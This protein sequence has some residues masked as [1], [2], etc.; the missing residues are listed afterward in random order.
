[1]A[2][3]DIL[4]EL[5]SSS[6]LHFFCIRTGAEKTRALTSWAGA[7]INMT[8]SLLSLPYAD[9]ILRYLMK[10]AQCDDKNSVDSNCREQFSLQ[11]WNQVGARDSDISASISHVF[12]K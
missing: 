7:S 9:F 12:E 8:S 10:D 3:D 6:Q 4:N 5:E 11:P 2:C 1:M